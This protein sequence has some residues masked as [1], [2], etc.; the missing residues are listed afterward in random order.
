MV[1][2][3]SQYHTVMQRMKEPRQFIQVVMGPRQVGKTTLIRQVLNDTDLPFSFF[4]ADNIP[5]TQ[6]DWIGD[7][8]A[9]VRAKMRLEALQECILII[10]EIQKINN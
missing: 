7:C 10:D 1:Y 5:A 8:W 6:T 4:T 3:R 2:K 9:N